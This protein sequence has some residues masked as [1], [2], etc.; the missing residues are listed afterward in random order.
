M[1]RIICRIKPP[2]M[3]NIKIEEND[4]ILLYKKD[5]NLLDNTILKP[6]E[7]KLNKIYDYDSSTKDIYN[8]EIEFNIKNNFNLGLFIYGHTGSGKT[9]TL[10]GDSNNNGIFD[11]I[12]SSLDYEFDIDVIN[13]THSGNYDLLNKNKIYIYAKNEEIHSTVEKVVITEKNYNDIR[14]KIYLSRITGISKLN[15]N[16]SRSHLIINIY[17]KKNN[18]TY[19]IVDLA[20]NE[21]KPNLSSK[22]NEK[23]VS[24][25]NSSLLSLKE[26]FRN[27]DKNYIPYRRSD[28]TKLIKKVMIEKKNT[29]N[30]IICTIHSGFPYFYDSVDTLNYIESLCIKV[31][32]KKSYN[33]RKVNYKLNVKHPNQNKKNMQINDMQNLSKSKSLRSYLEPKLLL[34]NE[35]N[36]GDDF[37]SD[38]EEIELSKKIENEDNDLLMMNLF[39]DQKIEQLSKNKG[40][41][42][43][44]DFEFNDDKPIEEQYID[45]IS[46]LSLESIYKIKDEFKY[47]KKLISLINNFIY[48]ISIK[49]YKTILDEKFDLDSLLHLKISTTALLTAVLKELDQV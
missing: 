48:K 42:N 22:E 30:L 40:S 8:E 34:N 15:D 18:C 20:G 43:F 19:T 16:S 45:H 2:Q 11:F 39:N 28:L 5:K 49:N 37:E 24:Y 41:T 32:K 4:K 21:R 44:D 31:K 6:Y 33:E 3:D 23:E 9:F 35:E 12:C 47:R 17:N 29:K 1:V 10:F 25:I 7:F 27:Y 38:D 13:L 26:C 46:N 14:N 36:Y